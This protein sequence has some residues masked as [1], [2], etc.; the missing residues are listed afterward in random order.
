MKAG[1]AGL[2]Y[3]DRVSLR[4]QRFNAVG[5]ITLSYDRPN[6]AVFVTGDRNRYLGN[7]CTCL[8]ANNT[9][10]NTQTGLS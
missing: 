4:T 9:N 7:N 10:Q 3:G 2:I 8:I 5:A 6:N 1:E